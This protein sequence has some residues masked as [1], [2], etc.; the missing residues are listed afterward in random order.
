VQKVGRFPAGK[1][2]HMLRH[3]FASR[4]V[5]AGYHLREVQV[6][7]GH[8][9]IQVTERYAHLAPKKGSTDKLAD[10]RLVRFYGTSTAPTRLNTNDHGLERSGRGSSRKSS[11]LWGSEQDPA[12][13]RT[14]ILSS[15]QKRF[16][17]FS[18]HSWRPETGRT[19]GSR[20]SALCDSAVRSRRPWRISWPN[21]SRQPL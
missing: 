8:S 19:S 18:N 1:G 15:Y 7:M 17:R 10:A 4:C 20:P 6:W 2:W 21:G 16:T 5:A 12:S 9:T 13:G 14:S 11:T 3:S